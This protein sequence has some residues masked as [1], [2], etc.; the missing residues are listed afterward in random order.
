MDTPSTMRDLDQIR[1]HEDGR[2]PARTVVLAVG[3]LAAACVLFAAG[4]LIG[5]DQDSTRATQREDPLARLDALA[6][7]SARAPSPQV[8][9]PSAIQPTPAASPL[10]LT[11]AREGAGTSTL[12]ASPTSAPTPTTLS[13]ASPSVAAPAPLR[14]TTAP[15]VAPLG[16]RAPIAD[17]IASVR[18]NP[19]N[20]HVG[21][22]ASEGQDGNYTLQVSSFRA[23][24][25]AQ[26]FAQRL[27]ERGHRAFVASGTTTTTTGTWH[28][29][30][31]GPFASLRDVSNYRQSFESRE[32]LPTFV[33]R[34]DNERH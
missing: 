1:E 2:D 8:T 34:R 12:T 15:P 4:L 6:A 32:R 5:R 13:A 3:G 19:V 33:V 30:R 11:E 16:Q 18:L 24:G 26:Q 27:R 14:V 31:I 7:Q 29:V 21:P 10:N 17:G 9:Y 23:L 25:G 28:R 20:S 22:P